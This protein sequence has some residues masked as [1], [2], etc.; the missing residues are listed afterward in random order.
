MILLNSYFSISLL[1]GHTEIKNMLI[2][3]DKVY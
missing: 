2:I 1:Y 3:I